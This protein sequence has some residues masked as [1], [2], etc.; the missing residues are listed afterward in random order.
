MKTFEH[1]FYSG[2]KRR[3]GVVLTLDFTK[4]AIGIG[5]GVW[6]DWVGLINIAVGPLEISLGCTR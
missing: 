3:Y 6:S 5:C 1:I 2:M 4:F